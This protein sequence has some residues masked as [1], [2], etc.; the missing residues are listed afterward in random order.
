MRPPPEIIINVLI[1]ISCLWETKPSTNVWVHSK[2][3]PSSEGS[4]MRNWKIGIRC[5]LLCLPRTVWHL[6][7]VSVCTSVSLFLI[8]ERSFLWFSTQWMPMTT[9]APT[10][11]DRFHFWHL[12]Q[13]DQCFCVSGFRGKEWVG[14]AGVTGL[15]PIW[16]AMGW[17][18]EVT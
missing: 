4:R 11:H 9:P 8:L 6:I 7:F 2:M 14:P 18:S 10:I 15:F 16:W 3:R 5:H 12:I 13:I 1:K 17:W